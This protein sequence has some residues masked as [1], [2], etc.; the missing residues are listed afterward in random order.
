MSVSVGD[1]LAFMVGFGKSYEIHKVDRITPSGRIKCGR[2]D[3]NP[4]LTIRNRTSYYGPSVG[5]PV[6]DEIRH[7]VRREFLIIKL[8]RAQ[9]GELSNEE[10]E[11]AYKVLEDHKKEEPS[12]EEE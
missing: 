1:E 4:D 2:W 8:S 6:T 7:R 11:V 3:L 9:W 10:L 12:E 5:V